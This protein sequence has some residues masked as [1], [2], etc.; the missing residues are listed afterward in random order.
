MI[1][2]DDLEI[3]EMDGG[4]MIIKE[5]SNEY[6]ISGGGTI[7]V[8]EDIEEDEEDSGTMVFKNGIDTM[9]SND[10]TEDYGATMVI[11]DDNSN[12]PDDDEIFVADGKTVIFK[13]IVPHVNNI[14]NDDEDD[15]YEN[16]G[17]GTMIIKDLVSDP[18]SP[19]KSVTS[20][21]LIAIPPPSFGSPTKN[22][23][24]VEQLREV[25]AKQ[26]GKLSFY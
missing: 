13:D 15:D 26:S 12:F 2:K 21:P 22:K 5:D 9:I 4:T 16:F 19:L 23:S 18:N 14:A 17:A 10:M 7:K 1:V 8:L 20:K 24:E 11:K 6:E 25:T 3:V